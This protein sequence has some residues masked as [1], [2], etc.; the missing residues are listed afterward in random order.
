MV[1]DSKES[2]KKPMTLIP[3]ILAAVELA[4]T[5]T[6]L[7]I[8]DGAVVAPV[9]LGTAIEV[10]TSVVVTSSSLTKSS[11]S[12]PGAVAVRLSGNPIDFDDDGASRYS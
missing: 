3:S 7:L 4:L 8:E 6:T 12:T 11:P 1:C 5:R 2:L 9:L 10:V